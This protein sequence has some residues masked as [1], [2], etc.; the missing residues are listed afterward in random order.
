MLLLVPAHPARAG[1]ALPSQTLRPSAMPS[2]AGLAWPSFGFIRLDNRPAPHPWQGLLACYWPT[3]S[4]CSSGWGPLEAVA[5]AS[6][7]SV[8]VARAGV[9]AGS[10]CLGAICRVVGGLGTAFLLPVVCPAKAPGSPLHSYPVAGTLLAIALRIDRCKDHGNGC[11]PHRCA[12]WSWQ[13]RDCASAGD[14]D[15]VEKTAQGSRLQGASHERT[16]PVSRLT[17][18][19]TALGRDSVERSGFAAS[20]DPTELTSSSLIHLTQKDLRVRGPCC[21]GGRLGAFAGWT[22]PISYGSPDG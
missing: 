17:A 10:A 5:E 8:E 6:A 1:L 21:A 13:L 22:L 9:R 3:D 16:V 20:L 4:A 12:R 2:R 19:P 11:P 18:G 15:S 7:E 14:G